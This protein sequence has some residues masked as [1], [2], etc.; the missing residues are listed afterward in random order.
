MKKLF[1][2]PL[3]FLLGA[4]GTQ[5]NNIVATKDGGI[6]IHYIAEEALNAGEVVMTGTVAGKVKKNGV[7]GDMPIGVV[8][9][10]ASQNADVWIVQSGIGYVLPNAA[11]TPTIAYVIYSSSTTAGRVSQSATLPAVA[12]HN[13]EVGHWLESCAQGVICRATLHF[14]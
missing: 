14:N 1:L 6:A 12:S 10:S 7:D 13:R 2:L 9:E 4:A 8:Y 5:I 3:L 11:D